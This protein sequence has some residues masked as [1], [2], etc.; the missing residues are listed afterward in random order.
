MK[1]LIILALLSLGLYA[2]K[3]IQ[4]KHMHKHLECD[5]PI[6]FDETE[7]EKIFELKGKIYKILKGDDVQ[8]SL[9]YVLDTRTNKFKLIKQ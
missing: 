4:H 1:T 3:E 5:K 6:I 8:S 9:L 7:I 2:E